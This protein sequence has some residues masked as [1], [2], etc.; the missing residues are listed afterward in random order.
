MLYFVDDGY[1]ERLIFGK[2]S[3]SFVGV[4]LF[5]LVFPAS[6]VNIKYCREAAR[7]GGE[8]V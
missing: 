4:V 5:T 3:V 6:A 7:K 2:I 8:T 1:S